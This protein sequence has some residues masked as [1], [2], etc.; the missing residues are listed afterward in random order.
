MLPLPDHPAL[1][2]SVR[3]VNGVGPQVENALSDKGITAV[4]DLWTLMPLRYQDRRKIVPIADLTPGQDVLTAGRVAAVKE[5]RFPTG[6]R[7][8]ELTLD[9]GGGRLPALWF[10]FPTHLRRSLTPGKPLMLYGRIETYRDR[11]QMVH[12]ELLP[13]AVPA[14]FTPEVRP[15]YPEIEGVRPGTLRRIMAAAARQLAG[16]PPIFPR[17]WLERHELADPVE[18]LAV[19]HHPPADRE[20][21]LPRPEDSKAWRGLALFEL[22]FL[23]LALARSRS[24]QARR[25]AE[26]M[27]KLGGLTEK[28]MSGLPFRLTPGQKLAWGEIKGDLSS[29]RP[30][31]RL[32]QGDVGAGKTV[33]ALAAA[34]RA[35][36]CGRQ[37][38]I[39]A[40]TE[41][42]AR[43]HFKTLAP[44]A[45]RLGVKA[46]LLV[47]S[48]PETEKAGLRRD[49][50]EGR[51]DLVV[52]TQALISQ[53]V[54]F[55]DL[56]LA[57][58]DEQHRFGVAQRLALRAK[59]EE[60][61]LLVMTATP[62]PRSLALTL[63]G[64]LDLSV[65][66]DKPPGR[67]RVKTKV[68]S[69]EDREKA[70]RLLVRAVRRGG[71]AYVV[72]PRIEARNGEA[73]EDRPDEAVDHASAEDLFRHI[74]QNLLPDIEVG[75]VHGRMKAEE[76]DEV[77]GRFRR[78]ELQALVATTVIEVG[79]DVP[80]AS[81]ILVEGAERFGLAQLHQLRGR[82]GRGDREGLCLL[83]SG[84]SDLGRL[85]VLA[86]T[87]DGFVVA[88][89]DL[90]RRGPG[91]PAGLRQSG[92][93]PFSWARLPRDLNLLLRARDL[94]QEIIGRDPQLADP[95]FRLVR[96]VV[97]RVEK[98]IRAEA[99][100]AG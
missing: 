80:E 87:D 78:G 79:L 93:P 53:G 90:Q 58:I 28:F 35:V 22:L 42:L 52:G 65:I 74:S 45:E 100:D 21:P 41:I 81:V 11:L 69:S 46:A 91:D 27:E 38:A 72:A 92:L 85:E 94:A 31:N 96:E 54:E 17:N 7:Y 84:A 64:D 24:G 98:V 47:G 97:D 73:E 16:V 77:L 26:A 89:E 29:D 71:R 82:I 37:A 55:K 66:P 2:Q 60:C 62:I 40:P 61:D 18:A 30:M 49:L 50:A 15:V 68:F 20:G 8:F 70:H 1:S 19:L 63:Y 10:R 14:G 13:G 88:E 43:Q 76:Q 67:A 12:P 51:V 33:I 34:F 39:M 9:D 23:Q 95:S 99:A 32:L 36:G 48:L 5:G 25:P 3:S 57:V 59:A 86:R 4:A 83:V 6:R 56:G 75:L 44:E